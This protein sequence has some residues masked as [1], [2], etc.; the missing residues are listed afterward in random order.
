MLLLEKEQTI[1]WPKEKEQNITQKTK[2]WATWTPLKMGVNSGALEGW[3]V[4][5][6]LV[7]P[8][9]TSALSV[10]SSSSIVFINI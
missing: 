10:E 9:V 3:A 4:P 6:P 5:T 7:T 2:E 8:V 1:Q